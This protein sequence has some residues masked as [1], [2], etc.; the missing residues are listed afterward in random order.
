MS[1]SE[2][3]AEWALSSAKNARASFSVPS[4]IGYAATAVTRALLAIATEQHEA[5]KEQHTANLIAYLASAN[6]EKLA[7]PVPLNVMQSMQAQIEIQLG[8]A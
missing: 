4:A 8:L 5:R 6:R 7:Y 1:T 2:E 3:H